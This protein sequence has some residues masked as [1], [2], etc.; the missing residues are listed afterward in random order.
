MPPEQL[1]QKLDRV[2][3]GRVGKLVGERAYRERVRNIVD[4]AI[5][6]DPHVVG[7]RP[8]FATYIGDRIRHVGDALLEFAGA[9]VDYVRLKGRFDC[10]KYG[11]V[12]P[13]SRTP[14]GIEPCLEML[15]ADGVI[16]IVLDLVLASPRQLDGRADLT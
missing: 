7:G 3:T 2:F 12:Q 4:R 16:I 11:A 15:C 14:L 10:R 9:A 8:I 13:G 6:A 5:P 1:V